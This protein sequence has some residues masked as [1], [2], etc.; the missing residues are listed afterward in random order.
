MVGHPSPI[1]ASSSALCLAPSFKRQWAAACH[2]LHLVVVHL[3]LLACTGAACLS[4]Y[5][6]G[7]S[8][9]VSQ[10]VWKENHP[11]T[12]QG[13]LSSLSC[14]IHFPSLRQLQDGLQFTQSFG[15]HLNFKGGIRFR[16]LIFRGLSC[17]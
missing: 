1:S 6:S 4:G 12:R 5:I 11:C 17:F 9:I 15:V 8:G 7:F 13:D 2:T 10:E 3:S 14:P 16:Q